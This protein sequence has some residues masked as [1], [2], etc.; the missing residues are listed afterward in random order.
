MTVAEKYD[1][2]GR[3]AEGQPAVDNFAN[4]VWAC[5]LLGYQNPDLT[6]HASQV[7]DW[8]SGEDGLDLRALHADWVSLQAAVAA[9]QGA[10]RLQDDQLAALSSAWQGRGAEA[11]REFLVRH[12]DTSAVAAAAV[13]S[14]ADALSVLRDNLWQMIDSK[15]AATLAIDERGHAHRG[16]WLAAAQTVTTGVGD[17]AAASE[18][19]DQEVKPFVDNDIHSEWISAMRTTTASVAAS[20]A[21]AAAGLAAEPAAVFQVPGDLGPSWVP[22]PSEVSVPAEPVWSTGGGGV[23]TFPAVSS[24]PAVSGAPAA[25]IATPVAPMAAPP[26]A[27]PIPRR[28]R[29][30]PDRTPRDGGAAF[31][32]GA[33]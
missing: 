11:S 29:S 15:V 24:A 31:H 22:T 9:T 3:L 32:A 19:I 5:R 8:Y 18:M 26:P 20:Y 14:A 33:W 30:R 27:T 10:L 25:P 7:R 6:S 23:A 1:V 2:A 13:R 28:A 21:A 16:D 12:A 4:Y 17:R